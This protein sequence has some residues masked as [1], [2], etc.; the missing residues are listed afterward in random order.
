MKLLILT[1]KV[2]KNDPVLGFF[3]KWIEE[4]S[5]HA[6]EVS[7]I[8]LYKGEFDLPN[9]VKVYSL[10]KEEKLKAKS[11]KLKALFRFYKYIWDLRYEYDSVF[12]HMNQIYVVLG[13]IFWIIEGKKIVLWYVHRAKSFS[14]YIAEKLVNNI[15]TSSKESF[16]LK[17][18]KVVYVGHGVDTDKF[19][20]TEYLEGGPKKVLYVG[21]ITPIKDLETFINAAD[22]LNTK[23]SG[24]YTFKIIGNPATKTDY[25]YE[26]K[27]KELIKN[28]KLK[29]VI[30][31][32]PAVSPSELPEL[33]ANSYLTVNLSPSG[34]MDKTVLE[35][36]ASN[37][38]AFVSNNAF[39]QILEEHE[40][41]F[42]FKQ[43]NAEDLASKIE[44][45]EKLEN[46]KDIVNIISNKVRN[47]FN[48]NNL[49]QKICEVTLKLYENL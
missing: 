17:S 29:N 15:I 30:H 24:V 48:I 22:I 23:H 43:E 13:G 11:Y 47:N 41:M 49:I 6:E 45:F 46:K 20:S 28:K 8:C 25:E 7:V 35:S 44:N 33:Y 31:F 42:M 9:N 12:V 2:D 38:P 34:G 39:K 3:H 14:L 32:K 5:K 36:W 10:G 18:E 40:N 37:R 21:R 27:L 16:T 26:K 4:F 1:Q 19:I